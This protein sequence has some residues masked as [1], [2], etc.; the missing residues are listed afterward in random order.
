M[1]C[2]AYVVAR[3]MWCLM[4]RRA[5]VFVLIFMVSVIDATGEMLV[6]AALFEVRVWAWTRRTC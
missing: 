6:T 1:V 5:R 4:T 2:R 3:V